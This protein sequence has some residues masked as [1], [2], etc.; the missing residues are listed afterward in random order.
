MSI[1]DLN[2]LA[3]RYN[4]NTIPIIYQAGNSSEQWKLIVKLQNSLGKVEVLL[5]LSDLSR[6]INNQSHTTATIEDRFNSLLNY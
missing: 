1:E 4:D 6:R 3:A 5:Y 2:K